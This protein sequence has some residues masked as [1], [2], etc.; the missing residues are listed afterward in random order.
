MRFGQWQQKDVCGNTNFPVAMNSPLPPTDPSCAASIG[1][2]VAGQVYLCV[3]NHQRR[4]M[5]IV[6]LDAQTALN[7]YLPELLEMLPVGS[8]RTES[9][10]RV[11]RPCGTESSY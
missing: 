1:D 3:A 6:F 11:R 2:C 8:S 5:N 9:T 7:N 4:V 10:P